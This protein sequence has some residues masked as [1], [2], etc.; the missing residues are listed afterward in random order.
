MIFKSLRLIAVLMLALVCVVGCS[1]GDS[2][3]AKDAAADVKAA[4][5]DM[6]K[7][8]ADAVASSFDGLKGAYLGTVKTALGEMGKKVEGLVARKDALPEAAQ[9]PVE[10]ALNSLLAS[11]ENATK[12]LSEVENANEDNFE[13]KRSEMDSAM[14]DLKSNF[15]KAASLFK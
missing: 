8:A 1:N 5:G 12:K 6:G 15:E 13:A 2:D 3:S 14:G 10:G 7:K 4:A 9:K 11:H